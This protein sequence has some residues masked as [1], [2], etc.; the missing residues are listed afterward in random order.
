MKCTSLFFALSDRWT[1]GQGRT[2]Q[3]DARTQAKIG[4]FRFMSHTFLE[5]DANQLEGV[6]G[7]V[8]S[9][10]VIYAVRS[11]VWKILSNISGCSR[12]ERDGNPPL[13]GLRSFN[14]RPTLQE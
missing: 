6:G 5:L 1:A 14:S 9:A 7:Q 11:Y 4:N 8:R 13:T 3:D 12:K 10:S 2:H